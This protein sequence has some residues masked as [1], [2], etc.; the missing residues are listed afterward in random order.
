MVAG[1]VVPKINRKTGLIIFNL[2]SALAGLCFIVPFVE[3][4]LILQT[5]IL[6]FVRIT[7]VFS[8]SLFSVLQTETFEASIK[9]TAIGLTSGFS[10]IGRV[11]I[12]VM[13]DTMNKIGIH[14]LVAASFLYL[15]LGIIPVLFLKET[16]EEEDET[17]DDEVYLKK[18]TSHK[19]MKPPVLPKLQKSQS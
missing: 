3:K 13:I 17:D 8:C 2:L 15:L 1:A 7:A 12:P 5:L 9:S 16:Y 14:P 18:L 6:S 4:S 10:Q 19:K 11:A